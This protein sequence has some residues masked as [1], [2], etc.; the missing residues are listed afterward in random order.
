MVPT[1]W[2]FSRVVQTFSGKEGLVRVAN[3]K[4][5]RSNDPL[6]N[7]LYFYLPRTILIIICE[8]WTIFISCKLCGM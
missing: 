5:L 8:I 1:K 7:S 2:P 3:V 6:A 4:T